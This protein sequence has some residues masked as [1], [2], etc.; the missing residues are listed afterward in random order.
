M[1]LDVEDSRISPFSD[2]D[3]IITCPSPPP[4]ALRVPHHVT[5]TN[6][7]TMRRHDART[8]YGRPYD[9]HK[10]WGHIIVIKKS[11]GHAIFFQLIDSSKKSGK[12]EKSAEQKSVFLF[13]F[14]FAIVERHNS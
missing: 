14:L 1:V 3:L 4:I 9:I 10:S 2:D 11:D 12:T 5:N 7:E 8:E 6:H 13:V